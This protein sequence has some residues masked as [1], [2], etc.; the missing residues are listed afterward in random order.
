MPNERSVLTG[1]PPGKH[2]ILRRSRPDGRT[3][4]RNVAVA[5]CFAEALPLLRE[6]QKQRPGQ[7]LFIA[8]TPVTHWE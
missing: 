2:Y 8:D 7:H 4:V 5:K 3:I 1:K 6:L